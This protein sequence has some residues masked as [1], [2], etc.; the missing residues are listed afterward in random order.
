MPRITT[1]SHFKRASNHN[2]SCWLPSH[3]FTVSHFKRASNHN[4][5]RFLPNSFELFHISKEHQITTLKRSASYIKVLFHIS[6]EH[7][8]TTFVVFFALFFDCFT[9]QKSIKSQPP[10]RG[11]ERPRTVSHFKRASNHNRDLTA[12]DVRLLFHISKEHQITTAKCAR[13][14]SPQL[15]HIS[16]EHQIT[17]SFSSS[18]PPAH[19]F[20]FQK[21]IKSQHEHRACQQSQTVSH[22][23]RASN[24]NRIVAIPA[25][26]ELFHISKEH[27]I[28]TRRR[29]SCPPSDCFTF[30]KSIKS[31]LCPRTPDRRRTVSHFKR[32][33][34]HNEIAQR[35]RGLRTVSHF[36]RASNHNITSDLPPTFTLFHISKEHQITTIWVDVVRRLY[37]FTFQ[38][39]IKS[40]PLRR[41]Y[42]GFGTVSHFKRASNHNLRECVCRVSRLFHISKE[43][44]IT[45][46]SRDGEGRRHCFTF[47]KSNYYSPFT[48]NGV[49]IVA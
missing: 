11:I 14:S 24:H 49:T 15:F 40:Q 29:S 37:C 8:I 30:Q 20:T 47:Q 35:L 17:T 42:T 16:K 1:V 39:S 25:N 48:S 31:Q 10:A 43:H 23:K 9:F 28:T 19:C 32:A 13:I 33:S 5:I 34:N 26:P 46:R 6:K 3:S 22:F 45:T 41:H 18:L 4:S 21:S 2:C 7:Q 38:K 12:E 36:K 27:Q 44:Q